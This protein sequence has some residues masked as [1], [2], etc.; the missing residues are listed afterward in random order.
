[1]L[2]TFLGNAGV[3]A[4]QG[5]RLAVTS[6]M[7]GYVPKTRVARFE[8]GVAMNY[9]LGWNRALR[10]ITLDAAEI[11][12][13][14]DRFGSL[15]VG[16]QGDLV[17]YN[18]DPFEYATQVERVIVAGASAFNRAEHQA[19]PFDRVVFLGGGPEPGCCLGW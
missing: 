13:I 2:H 18:G 16:K 12:G 10:A 3:L 17:L 1:L 14:A 9:G 4:D 19:V 7:E 6:G 5:I 15:E 11:L 8:A